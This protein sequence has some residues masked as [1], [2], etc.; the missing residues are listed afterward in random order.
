MGF[1]VTWFTPA[2]V[3][4]SPRILVLQVPAAIKN[5]SRRDRLICK[6]N[7]SKATTVALSNIGG[8]PDRLAPGQSRPRGN[9]CIFRRFKR[10]LVLHQSD[11]WSIHA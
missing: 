3:I 1:P 6:K 5:G 8:R 11:Q 10:R 4:W 9:A 2:Q 7:R